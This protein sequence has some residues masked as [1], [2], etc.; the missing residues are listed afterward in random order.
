M[1]NEETMLKC[2]K[3]KKLQKKTI[4]KKYQLTQRKSNL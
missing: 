4:T 3:K 2:D 1:Q